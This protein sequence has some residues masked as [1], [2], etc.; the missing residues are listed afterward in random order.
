LRYYMAG[1]FEERFERE[2]DAANR[3]EEVI[4]K[5]ELRITKKAFVKDADPNAHELP[6]LIKAAWKA[7]EIDAE[8]SIDCIFDEKIKKYRVTRVGERSTI[9]RFWGVV[10]ATYPFVN[11]GS[12]DEIVCDAY[13]HVLNSGSPRYDHV[14]AAMRLPNNSIHWLTYQRVIMAKRETRGVPTVTVV[15]ELAPVDI[16]II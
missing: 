2:G 13:R 9:A 3:I 8:T 15:T 11:G 4:S 5:S 10:P 14:L 16:K 1:W 7:D 6:P 12:Y